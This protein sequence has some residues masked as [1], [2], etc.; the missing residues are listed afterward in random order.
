MPAE[1]FPN[2][3]WNALQTVHANFAMKN[4]HAARYP[5]DVVPYA[6]LAD[7]SQAD[8]S[9]LEELLAP[10]DP[11]YLIGPRPAPTK[12][13]EVGSPLDCFQMLFPAQPQAEPTA[14]TDPE[15]LRMTDP[16]APDMVA[17]TDLAF[18]GFFRRRTHQMGDYY[19]IRIG[20]ELVAMAGERLAIPGYREISAV[21]THPAHTGKGYAT[22]LMNRLL[23]DHASANLKSFLHVSQRNSRAIALYQRMGFVTVD[24]V[25]LWPV[26]RAG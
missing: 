4:S 13:L 6:A 3:V 23:R 25:S 18:P 19:G 14:P 12:L 2:L 10:N 15:I 9:P 8:L 11:V 21:V 26:S 7:P 5:A 17:L 24:S 20:G 1:P 16:H 22:I